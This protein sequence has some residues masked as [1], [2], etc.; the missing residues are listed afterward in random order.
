ME[1]GELAGAN[2]SRLPESVRLVV[3]AGYCENGLPERFRERL[4]VYLTQV[5]EARINFARNVGFCMELGRE[6]V[7]TEYAADFVERVS[8]L[9]GSALP[10]DDRIDAA[11]SSLAQLKV[12]F[13][14][15]PAVGS[16]DEGAVLVC[17]S[18]IFLQTGRAAHCL[19][20]MKTA[21]E[22]EL[23]QELLAFL[24]FVRLSHFWVSVHPEMELDNAISGF[25][26]VQETLLR[27][28]SNP[29]ERAEFAPF[30][31]EI[32]LA[33]TQAEGLKEIAQRCATAM[34]AHLNAGLACIWSI[35]DGQDALELKATAGKPVD[36]RKAKTVV[37]GKGKTGRLAKAG[38]PFLVQSE[39]EEG[40]SRIPGWVLREGFRAFVGYP[41]L[42]E[43]R[44][45]GMIA[46]CAD[47]PFP[48]PVIDE[49]ESV[50]SSMVLGLDRLHSEERIR[51]SE[52][53]YR[54]VGQAANDAIWDWDLLNDQVVWN[55]GLKTCFG[56][57]VSS[58][59]PESSWWVEALH[60]DDR[61]RVEH[62]LRA[63]FNGADN[64]WKDEYRFRC[65]D[66]SYATILDRGRL[67]RDGEGKPVRM[68][69]SML[70]LTERRQ[71]E[72]R[73]AFL[74]KL[75]EA[76]QP[77]YDPEEVTNE[78][79]RLLAEFIGAEHCVFLEIEE[80]RLLAVR[81]SYAFG[82][83]DKPDG[84]PLEVLSEE[85]LRLLRANEP[86]VV[87]DSWVDPQLDETMVEVFR[88]VKI[89]SLICVPLH[90]NGDFTAVLVV[91]QGLPR[92][93]TQQ[94]VKLVSLVAGRCWE[95]LERTR[96]ARQL[97]ASEERVRMA[98]QAAN[99]GTWDFDLV[100]GVLSWSDR[101][102]EIFGLSPDAP[103]DYEIFLSCLHPDDRERTDE[104]VQRSIDAGGDGFY[105]IDYRAVW[106][107]G[108]VRWI[109][110]TGGT[111]F[112]GS[113]E[114]KRAV[115][116]MGTCLDITDRKNAEEKLREV[117]SQLSE[118]DRRKDEFLATLAHE[119]RNPLAPIRTGLEVIKLAND[120]PETIEEVRVMME[121]QTKQL[122]ALVDDLLDVSRITR[123]KLELR[124]RRVELAEVVKD[125]VD[126]SRPFMDEANHVLSVELPPVPLYLNADPNRMAQILSNL[127]NN[128]ARYT[129]DGGCIQIIATLENS[130][131]KV[132]VADN[133]IGIDPDMI[134]RIFDM[135]AQAERSM[136][137]SHSGL[138][139]GL[140]LVKS[141]VELHQGR[142]EVT[143]AG[144]GKGSEF[145]V[146][147][148]VMEVG[149]G[150][151]PI[152]EIEAD[153]FG[154]AARGRRVLV[155]D[156]NVSAANT[157]A[158]VLKMLGNEVR[159]A[160]DG[161][162]GICEAEAFR[163]EVVFLDLG[164]PRM[165]GYAAAREIRKRDWGSD[166]Y[167]VA[168]TGWGAEADRRRTEE[169][170]FDRH[171]VKPAEPTVLREV[172][173]VAART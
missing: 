70:D 123:G 60:P 44:L 72:E 166:L 48:L 41:L 57:D 111:V 43:N 121:R 153:S 3:Q 133:G 155:V 140:T 55:E 130:E 63:F 135:F 168:L 119:L 16:Y 120:D 42:I 79:A 36:L 85:C 62:H 9:L 124:K 88:K 13:A 149:P 99:I 131:V 6:S 157:L 127:L 15:S 40:R 139:I 75:A 171:L 104:T 83:S 26:S 159:V 51:E 53:R 38:T 117:A 136:E 112:V 164:M 24:S 158:L 97:M 89:R 52:L 17:A 150:L 76:T 29:P 56:Y 23:F 32:G 118:A 65:S 109:V 163:P 47:R 165:D 100:R 134:G 146:Y 54:L 92:R 160:N 162:Q 105:N 19:E 126:S 64:V 94:E 34:V 69:G 122:I 172:L 82:S 103:I 28:T 170:G 156:D 68:V 167:L 108:E 161:E 67:V 90:K 20:A 98:V 132:S 96:T 4:F 129:P 137:R 61:E 21:A 45:V 5:S 151:A 115:R 116:F 101:C 30:G 110:A 113:K 77:L 78:T 81:G 145:S 141:L 138:G 154:N 27:E 35:G 142:I 50:V 2:G 125:A 102:K 152:G 144:T 33:L 1:G 107:N 106:P 169:A 80:G 84:W 11:I 91:H 93:W 66:G 87:R 71:I 148:P 173:S 22:E 74:A 59:S 18:Q 58:V 86:L 49:L 37:V 39:A 95:S 128:A 73:Q 147:F 8:D 7:D 12:D 10:G 114:N 31:K 25:L 46:M 14:N 143:S